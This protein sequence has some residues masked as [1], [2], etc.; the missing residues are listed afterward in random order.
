[1]PNKEHYVKCFLIGGLGIGI[2][3]GLPGVQA[4]NC[5]CCL[6]VILGGL[7]SGYL[8]CRWAAYPVSEGEGALV[9]LLSGAIGA[10]VWDILVAMSWAVTGTAQI[11]ESFEAIR[12][13]QDI[14]LPP[15]SEEMFQKM[16]ELFT[17]PILLGGVFL[18]V[19]LL[20]CCTLAPAGGFLAVTIWGRRPLPPGMGPTVI[21]PPPMMPPTGPGGP[22]PP[23][24]PAPGHDDQGFFFPR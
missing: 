2:L 4:G 7:L 1:V 12:H 20:I 22:T 10:V 5:C 9:G 17:N 19:F 6:W 15:G 14:P 11:Q 23:P 21:I 3:S 16:A 24:V 18:I 13:R 8:L